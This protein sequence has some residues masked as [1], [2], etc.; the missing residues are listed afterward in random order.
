MEPFE[1][2]KHRIRFVYLFIAAAFLIVLVNFT[3]AGFAPELMVLIP[4]FPFC[5]LSIL[6]ISRQYIGQPDTQGIVGAGIGALISV[7]PA[8]AI[9][10]Y[11][12]MTGW[13]GGA[14]I[15]LGLLYFFLPLYSVVIMALGYFSAEIVGLM[16]HRN[17]D[18][19]PDIFRT[20][21]LF[22]G[23]GLS[24]YFLLKSHSAYNLWRYNQIHDP[25]A[26]EIY[27]IDFWLFV[28]MAAG[29]W[30]VPIAVYLLTRR[31]KA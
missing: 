16:R 12:M 20:L 3:I 15:G 2:K 5:L 31:K 29:A 9:L 11:D 23:I 13:Q 7:L 1:I 30:L 4:A 28:I 25:S 19:L 8:T 6:P 21:S 10:A 24:F 26:A 27:A 17:F 14:D 18:R 22:I